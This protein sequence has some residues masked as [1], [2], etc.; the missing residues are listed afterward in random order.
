MCNSIRQNS[1]WLDIVSAYKGDTQYVVNK[2][3]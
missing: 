2:S 3:E 1:I